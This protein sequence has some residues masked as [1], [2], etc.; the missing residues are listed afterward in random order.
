MSMKSDDAGKAALEHLGFSVRKLS[1]VNEQK[2]ADFI[3]THGGITLL[4]ECKLRKDDPAEKKRM[5]AVL[6]EGRVYESKHEL[7]PHNSHSKNI[8]Q[9]FDQLMQEQS[10]EHDYKVLLYVADCENAS[11][12]CEQILDTLYGATSVF[13]PDGGVT[14]ELPCFF[15]HPSEF[16]NANGIDAA[17]V[18]YQYEGNWDLVL[19]LNSFSDRYLDLRES[20]LEQLFQGSAV[21]PLEEEAC[22]TAL[23]VDSAAPRLEGKAKVFARHFSS[24]DPVLR[25]LESKYEFRKNS[26]VQGNMKTPL[27]VVRVA[28]D[29][30]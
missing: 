1:E 25:F 30:D 19:C 26:L 16:F 11:A 21:D 14:R 29:A 5:D 3:A 22:G 27:F 2:R 28:K 7:G 15:Y 13:L 12:V 8:R 9:A 23:V 20:A 6:A 18:G 24:M 17:I 10:E 4:V